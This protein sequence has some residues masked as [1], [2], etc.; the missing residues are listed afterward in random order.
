[1]F[2]AGLGEA[3]GEAGSDLFAS[4]RPEGPAA[5]LSAPRWRRLAELALRTQVG[6]LVHHRLRAARRTDVPREVAERLARVY[7]WNAARN[8]RL[9]A[10]RDEVCRALTGAGVRVLVLKG[11]HLGPVLYDGPGAR[12]MSDVDLLVPREALGRAQALLA[13]RG[14]GPTPPDP[15]GAVR[16]GHHLPPLRRP[17]GFPIEV[18]WTLVEHDGLA[19]PLPESRGAWERATPLDGTGAWGMDL[20][21]A[22]VYSCRHLAIHHGFASTNGISGLMDV[23]LLLAQGRVALP[24]VVARAHDWGI[25]RAVHLTLAVARALLGAPVDDDTLRALHP[26][27][28]SAD[29]GWAAGRGL[30]L[31]NPVRGLF[32]PSG[33]TLL[34]P[35]AASRI[36]GEGS[37]RSVVRYAREAAFPPPDDLRLEYPSLDH[38]PLAWLA[39]PR[40]WGRL[41]W[42][43][44]GLLRWPLARGTLRAEQRRRDA[45]LA[46]VRPDA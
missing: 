26:G 21:D 14:Y 36:L 28:L 13:A 4:L 35:P 12:P 27:P 7:A 38:R 42:T 10:E 34:P 44:A 41:A 39:W 46:F 19:G 11:C 37:V 20:V 16:S 9:V 31:P 33:P 43:H 17:G 29:V 3:L 45:L 22:L 30:V 6:S 5:P 40:H 15:E 8:R 25:A 23:T 1:M 32:L 24:A 18:H 2:V